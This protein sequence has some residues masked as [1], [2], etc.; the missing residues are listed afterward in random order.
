[1]QPDVFLDT[2]M[3]MYI[4]NLIIEVHC[5]SQHVTHMS[6]RKFYSSAVT[7]TMKAKKKDKPALKT[8]TAL[9]YESSDEDEDSK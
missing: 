2:Y 7:F 4:G 8:K 6:L 1:M 3:C 5:V 9:L